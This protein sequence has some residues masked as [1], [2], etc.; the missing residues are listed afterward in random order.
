MLLFVLSDPS[1]EPFSLNEALALHRRAHHCEETP[2]KLRLPRDEPKALKTE[3]LDQLTEQRKLP[4]QANA[5]PSSLNIASNGHSV[6]C[7]FCTSS[8]A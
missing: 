4:R 6:K 3:T 5:Q 1:T 2:V 7:K 8:I